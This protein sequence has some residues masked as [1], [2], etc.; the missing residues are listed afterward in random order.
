MLRS[1]QTNPEPTFEGSQEWEADL[2]P[3]Q[4]RPAE[5]TTSFDT[6]PSAETLQSA[7]DVYFQFCHNQPYSLFHEDSFRHRLAAG[8]VPKHLAFA[9]LATTLRF[10]S[11][12]TYQE[13]RYDA[14]GGY[15]SES[16]KEIRLPWNGVDNA[17]G[18]SM[19]QAIFLLSVIDYT[20]KQTLECK[21]CPSDLSTYLSSALSGGKCQAGWIKGKRL[22]GWPKR[23]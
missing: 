17:A 4:G 2:I 1:H 19:L 15:A 13:S 22:L 21:S 7:A 12:S 20:G 6:L 18:I 5:H 10:S 9:F 16:W 23:A 8:T 14:I 11:E 3:N